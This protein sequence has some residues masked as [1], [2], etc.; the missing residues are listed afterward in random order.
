MIHDY[1]FD[2]YFLSSSLFFILFSDSF[3]IYFDAY[4]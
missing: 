4:Y 2:L 1:D 3:H